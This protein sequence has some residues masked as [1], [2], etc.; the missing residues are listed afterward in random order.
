MPTI[1]AILI[2]ACASFALIGAAQAQGSLSLCRQIKDDAA[3]LKCYDGLSTA[4]GGPTADGA[5]EVTEDKS[6]ITDA[7]I[8][9]GTLRTSDGKSQLIMRCRER[10]TEVAVLIRGFINCGTEVRV[11]YR[12]DQAQ[13]VEG[14]WNTSSS[15]YF[16]ISPSPIPF[17]RSLNDQSKIYFRLIDHH[18][19]PFDALFNVGKVSDVSSRLA[20]A[21]EWPK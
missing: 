2:A 20:Q 17:I 15:C 7:P 8:V 14:P 4:S 12:I 9:S 19:T 3:R 13:P 21:C 11:T 16:A 5:W 18:G 1:R 10:K 6:P